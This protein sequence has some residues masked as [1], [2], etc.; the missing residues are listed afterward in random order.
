MHY[1]LRSIGFDSIRSIEDQDRL[2]E[3]VLKNY[4]FKKVAEN[5]DHLLFAQISKEYG[6][7]IGV[8]VCGYYD[9][10]NLF[11]LEYYYPYLFGSQTSFCRQIAVERTALSESYNGACEDP[12]VGTTLIFQVINAVD[13]VNEKQRNEVYDSSTPVSLSG[14]AESGTILLPIEKN[15]AQIANE[16]KKQA[17]WNSLYDAASKGDEKA[18]NSLTLENFDAYTTAARRIRHEDVYTIVDSYF[19]P[20]GL[21]CNLYNIMGMITECRKIKNSVTGEPVFILTVSA[22][23]IPL[24]ICIHESDLTGEPENGRRF[25]GI[26]WLQG[27]INF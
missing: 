11:H 2:M 12:R 5:E 22:N 13:Y 16:S 1:Y 19:M 27:M 14:L 3:D 4:D 15:A 10:E 6:Q 21:E 24:D 8:M 17:E 7:D 23:G 25:K 20:F 9:R 18:Y 26:V